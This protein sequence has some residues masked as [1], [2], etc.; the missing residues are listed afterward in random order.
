VREGEH[1]PAPAGSRAKPIRVPD[2]YRF[3]M[4]MNTSLFDCWPGRFQL[5]GV[6]R[7]I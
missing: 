4:L 7:E 2:P 1:T 5:L 3:V 6:A